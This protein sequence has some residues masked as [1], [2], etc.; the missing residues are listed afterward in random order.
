MQDNGRF[1]AQISTQDFPERKRLEMWREVYGRA[2]A[3]V[4]IEPIGDTPFRANVTFDLFPD[5][6]LAAGSR[7]PGHYHATKELVA[8]GGKNIVVISVLRSGT[9]SATQFGRELID[10]V[11][12]ASVLAPHA[13]SS[14]TMLSEGSFITLALAQPAIAARAPRYADAFGRTIPRDNAALALLTRY[15]DM[16]RGEVEVSDP[17]LRRRISDHIL[18]LAALALGASGDCAEVARQRSA[19]AARLA[20]I[21]SDILH[22]IG[23]TDLSTEM[24]AL[25]HG[26]SPRYVRKLFEQTGSSFSDFV[27]AERLARAQRM[28]ADKRCAHLNIA[29]IAH[30]S[31]FGDVSYFHRVFRRHFGATPS[32]LRESARPSWLEQE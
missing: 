7:S 23:R 12:S 19:T 25:R 28:L 13:P 3:N 16:V 32:D 26:I 11:G 27:L 2:I 21:K 8:R 31:G 15:V 24:I 17:A 22:A 30:E 10:G 6:N 14:S 9:A 18:D 5:V 1:R 4:D 20:A 29:Q